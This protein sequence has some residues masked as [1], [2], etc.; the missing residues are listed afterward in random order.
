[1]ESWTLMDKVNKHYFHSAYMRLYRRLLKTPPAASFSDEEIL[2]Q[3]GLPSPTTLLRISRLRY[4]A[5]LY[6]CEHVTPWAVFRTDTEWLTPVDP[7][8][9]RPPMALAFDS[10]NHAAPRSGHSLWCMGK[11]A[12]LPSY[13]LEE[14]LTKGIPA[15][16]TALRRSG[17]L[18]QTP[19]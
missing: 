1:M 6:K 13:L 5:L 7:H 8:P 9:G 3:I 19:S 11:R 10:I 2:T 15:G 4:L 17:A 12:P 16:T 14:T 18:A